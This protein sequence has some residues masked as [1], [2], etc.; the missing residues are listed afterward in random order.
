M[1]S[2]SDNAV[3]EQ[4]VIDKNYTD[5]KSYTDNL[6][7]AI[8]DV[9]KGF[10]DGV[11]DIINLE[12]EI[13]NTRIDDAI[14]LEHGIN[15][16]IYGYNIKKCDWYGKS[17]S[18]TY[19]NINSLAKCYV[20]AN[21]ALDDISN[22]SDDWNNNGAQAF[23]VKLVE[24]CRQIVKQLVAEPFICPTACG[25]IQFEYEKDNGDYLEFEIYEDRIEVYKDTFTNGEE[26]FTLDGISA[27][28]R[29]R[30]MVVDFYG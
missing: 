7:K 21:A 23:S 17:I 14:N 24:K 9:M 4:L 12:Y 6:K 20:A 22:L 5:K 2:N 19:K 25:S 27:I 1:Y 13:N 3:V 28:D 29:M 11:N 30:Q 15:N 18:M 16:T 8:E 10:L 26:E